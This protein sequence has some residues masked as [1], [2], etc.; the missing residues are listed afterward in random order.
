M[1]F[2]DE[3]LMAYA[4]GELPPAEA[5][6]VEA[7][8]A[9]DPSL[10]AR[11]ARFRNVR[12]ALRLAYDSV[13]R[14][15]I[16]DRFRALLGDMAIKE[17][18]RPQ[19]A[20]VA[21]LAAARSQSEAKKTRPRFGAPAWAA[22]AASLVV[23]VLAGRALLATGDE[24]FETRGAQIYAGADLARILDT[25]LASDG[26]NA[27]AATSIGISFRAKDGGYCRT[28]MRAEGQNGVTG[29]ACHEREGWAVRVASAARAPSGSYQQAGSTAP[30]VMAMV[31]QLIDGEALDGEQERAARTH[32][33]R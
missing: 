26:D 29:L 7:A 15:P 27:T 17:P 9:A 22:I 10:A 18:D 5:K 3:T 16:P 24:L 1:R 20:P 23:G 30:A 11:V 31:D 2:D 19:S 12:R 14:E 8:M 13:T 4:D 6:R 28:F 25:R 33:W 21:D 32:H